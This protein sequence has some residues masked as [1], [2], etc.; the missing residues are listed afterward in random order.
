MS[1]AVD[2]SKD[3]HIILETGAADQ[4]C[5]MNGPNLGTP[6]PNEWI[7]QANITFQA[8]CHLHNPYNE[9]RP[10][11]ISHGGQVINFLPL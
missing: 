8:T 11:Q 3:M 4:C 7:K 1:Q 10:V 6:L 9:N 5:D 2:T